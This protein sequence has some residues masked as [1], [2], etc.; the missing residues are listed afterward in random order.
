MITFQDVHVAYPGAKTPAVDKFSLEVPTG[1]TT[2]LLGSSGCG[3][4]T[5]IRCV[6]R[7]VQP[8]SGRIFIDAKDVS[9]LPPIPLRRSIGYV[10]QDAGLLPH[11]SVGFNI[12]TILR[13]NGANAAETR[14][15]VRKTAEQVGLTTEQLARYP[16]ELSGG[17][18]QRAGVARALAAD[19]NILLMDE[20]FGAVDPI[21]RSEMQELM[22]SL[23]ERLH[24][25]VI[26]V[27]HDVNEAL[28]LADQVVLL[29]EGAKIAQ[30]G[31]PEQIATRPA[32]DF[33]RNFIGMESK[34]LNIRHINGRDVVVDQRGTVIG[35]LERDNNS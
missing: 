33:V 12:G 28:T 35:P 2:V 24:K 4:T 3:K 27:T 25:T 26:L 9:Q 19:P 13:L 23:Q 18:R 11:R 15:A 7:M 10:L 8:S 31:T 17:Q 6:N 5:L 30:V 14:E 34:H 21:V 22:L 32:N 20:P 1:Q 29:Q 16:H